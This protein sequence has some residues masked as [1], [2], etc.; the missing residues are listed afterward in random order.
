MKTPRPATPE[1]V[2]AALV[3]LGHSLRP[4]AR[5]TIGFPGI[6]VA[7]R[8]YSAVNFEGDWD[9]FPLAA[10]AEER[11]G[12][13]VRV[14]NDADIQGYGAIRGDGVEVVITLGTGFGS[15]LFVDGK[16]VPNLELGHHC[17]TG[18]QTYEQSLG[19][20][21]LREVGETEW[22]QRL[23]EAIRKLRRLF[24]FQHL[25]L[26]GGNS[27]LVDLDLSDDVEIISNDAGLLGG[28]A[29]WRGGE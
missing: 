21:A 5:V 18:D 3:D 28:I 8:V 4:F 29:L 6:I 25:Y 26:G 22:N 9:A 14:A 13:P 20:A 23:A 11:L 27:R 2:V 24:S 1:A 10:T 15:A 19:L 7:G 16:L 12:V 17:M